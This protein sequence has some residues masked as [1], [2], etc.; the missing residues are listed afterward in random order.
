MTDELK[1]IAS[2]LGDEDLDELIQLAKSRQ[3]PDKN[4]QREIAE[5]LASIRSMLKFFTGLVVF[6]LIVVV[7]GLLANMV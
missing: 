3:Q 1:K 2:Q 6:W 5:H 7:L 4:Y